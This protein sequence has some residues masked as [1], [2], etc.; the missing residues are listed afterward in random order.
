[1]KGNWEL[2]IECLHNPGPGHYRLIFYDDNQMVSYSNPPKPHRSQ[3]YHLTEVIRNTGNIFKSS[4]PFCK[5]ERECNVLHKYDGPEVIW[6]ASF[7][8][9]DL[10]YYT[11]NVLHVIGS[12]VKDISHNLIHVAPMDICVLVESTKR[13]FQLR[14][15][16][17]AFTVRCRMV[18]EEFIVAPFTV[19][20]MVYNLKYEHWWNTGKVEPGK[21]CGVTVDSVSR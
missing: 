12:H 17:I 20:E 1:M 18:Q 8:D 11:D 4:L 19:E 7:T 10:E 2:L 16:I 21:Q 14:D 15:R 6:D 5:T 3:V 9:S 13:A